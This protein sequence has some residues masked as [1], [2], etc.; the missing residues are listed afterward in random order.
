[1]TLS[2]VLPCYNE[3][4]NIEATVRDAFRL[5][6]EIEGEVIVVDDGSQ[7]STREILQTLP[8]RII[9]HAR[10]LGYGA[11]VR[12]GCDNARGDLIVFMDSDGQF[13]ARDILRLL[14]YVEEFPF[15]A[16]E[17]IDR[18]DPFMRSWNARI[19]EYLVRLVLGVDVYDINCGMKVFRREIWPIIRPRHS[20]GALFNAEM[21]LRLEKGGIPWA[22]IPVPH[23]PRMA[24]QS[25]GANVDV[26]WKMLKELWGL[27]KATLGGREDYSSRNSRTASPKNQRV[28]DPALDCR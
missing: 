24:G 12:S 5:F 9:G 2:L 13:H 25:T 27:R 26:I 19:Y 20:T 14:R 15:V 3:E 11:A 21:F 18:A 10:N 7:D 22:K 23:Y 1:M 28:T 16:G 6:G 8:V 17:R 4:E